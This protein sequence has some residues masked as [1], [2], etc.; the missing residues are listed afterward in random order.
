MVSIIRISEVQKEA[1]NPEYSDLLG[2]GQ[3]S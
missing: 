2:G 3:E 1:R